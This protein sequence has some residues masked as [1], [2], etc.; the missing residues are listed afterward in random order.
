MNE[1][2]RL[3]YRSIRYQIAL[4]LLAIQTTVAITMSITGAWIAS[5]RVEEEILNRI[6]GISSVLSNP[7]FPLNSGIMKRL[8]QLT[9]V[10][11]VST[12]ISGRPL[13]SSLLLI[14]G[15]LPERSRPPSSL[16][17]SSRVTIHN[18][19]HFSIDIPIVDPN[20]RLIALYPVEL[21][22]NAR[23][24]ALF[25]PIL[26]GLGGLLVMTTVTT[27]VARRLSGRLAVIERGIVRISTGEFVDLELN[28][29]RSDEIEH[30][31]EC[32]NHMSHQIVEMQRTIET[33]GRMRVLAQV[34]SG[35]AHQ[36]RN[37]VS[38]A[39]MAIQLHSK[40]CPVASRDE[41]VSVALRQLELTEEQVRGL[42]THV[43]A[44]KNRSAAVDLNSIVREVHSLLEPNAH[45]ARV[46]LGTDLAHEPVI[47]IGN[48]DELRT[49]IFN[50]I[51]NAIE[52]AHGGG[53]VD[54]CACR[55]SDGT[56]I[57]TISDNG[58]GIAPSI[59]EQAGQPFV[60]SKPEG[61]GLGLYLALQVAE[62]HR[63]ELTWRRERELTIFEWRWAFDNGTLQTD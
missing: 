49:A 35:L 54:I 60:T 10:H 46:E 56:V 29:K 9:G 1:T 38:G 6:D 20:R 42:T 24:A 22:K 16:N 17:R 39:R 3:G 26:Q 2:N 62:R 37:S 63:S 41:S 44:D 11:F 23:R 52:A 45:H 53:R 32:I 57:L 48:A 30:L 61:L 25:W 40:R 18:V 13:D 58:T 55:N 50:L 5:A 12:D 4:P 31:A 21:W 14:P 7:Q 33:S 19:E 15:K 28:L 47:I 43:H 34:A 36:L 51:N 8:H 59:I 27:L